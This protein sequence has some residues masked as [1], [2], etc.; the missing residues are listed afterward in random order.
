MNK[1]FLT[2]RT[3]NRYRPYRWIVRNIRGVYEPI[4]GW[5]ASEEAAR[6]WMAKRKREDAAL[7]LR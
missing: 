1:P 3:R 6:D 2:A 4:S 7:G 5:F